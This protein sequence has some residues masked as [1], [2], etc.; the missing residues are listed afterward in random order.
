MDAT[1]SFGVSMISEVTSNPQ[2]TLGHN[3]DGMDLFFDY[4]ETPMDTKREYFNVGIW[5]GW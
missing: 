3:Q 4:T 1:P 5:L 2:L